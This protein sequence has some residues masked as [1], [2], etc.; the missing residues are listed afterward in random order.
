MFGVYSTD[1]RP[2][3]RVT[4]PVKVEKTHIMSICFRDM[5]TESS[6]FGP[7]GTSSLI[8]VTSADSY[9][10]IYAQIKDRLEYWK[11]IPTE[12]I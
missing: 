10:H 6:N 4:V 5:S 8:A 9:I 11:G 12:G 1:M 3:K 7:I 2:L